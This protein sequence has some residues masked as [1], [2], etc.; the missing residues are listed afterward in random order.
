MLLNQERCTVSKDAAQD[1]LYLLFGENVFG[2]Y[3]K[4]RFPPKNLEISLL[5]PGLPHIKL[6]LVYLF[7]QKEGLCLILSKL[8][9]C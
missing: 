2:H 6:H 9:F 8:S 4:L 3:L 7:T 1:Y 5:A